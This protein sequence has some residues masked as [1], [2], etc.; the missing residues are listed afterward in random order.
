MASYVRQR[1]FLIVLIS[2]DSEFGLSVD[3]SWVF[4]FIAISIILLGCS[5]QSQRYLLLIISGYESIIK[6]DFS[7]DEGMSVI[8]G[9]D[10]PLY[11]YLD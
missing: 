2:V 3:V 11:I 6:D 7:D 1:P 8:V 4:L 10:N 5:Y 9:E